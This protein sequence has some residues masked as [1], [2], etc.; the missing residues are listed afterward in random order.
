MRSLRG[1]IAL[2]FIVLILAVFAAVGLLAQH[3]VERSVTDM[4]TKHVHEVLDLAMLTVENGYEEYR[5][6]GEALLRERR[7]ALEDTLQLAMAAVESSYRRA[8]SGVITREAA[9]HSAMETL[10]GMRYADGAGYF[11]VQNDRLPIPMMLMHAAMPELEWKPCTHPLMYKALGDGSNLTA[12]FVEA[13]RESE[14]G[15]AFV[16]YRWPKPTPEGLTEIEPKLSCVQL[17]EPWGWVVGTGLYVDD[18]EDEC[19]THL[20]HISET[21]F[22]SLSEIELGR[23][24]YLFVFTDDGEILMHPEIADGNGAVF[25]DSRKKQEILS[26]LIEAAE[27][28][29]GRHEYLGPKPQGGNGVTRKISFVRFFEPLGW[30]IGAAVYRSELVAPAV[31][32]G[33]KILWITAG[34][35]VVAVLLALWLARGISRPLAELADSARR[36]E[37]EGI[38]A[39]SLPVRGTSETRALG[40]CLQNMISSLC[41]REEEL[42]RLSFLVASAVSPLVMADLEGRLTYVNPAF[43]ATWGYRSEEEVLG[44]EIGEFWEIDG[45]LEELRDTIWT[46]EAVQREERARKADG[47]FFD[48]QFSAALVRDNSG[49]PIALMASSVDITARRRA[50]AEIERSNEE[51]RLINRKLENYS[52][53]I[54]HDLKEPIRSIRTFSEFIREDYAE[55]FDEEAADYFARIIRAS[56]RMARMIDDLLLLSRVGRYDVAFRRVSVTDLVR[57]AE[58]NLAPKLEDQGATLRYPELP[59][60]VCQ[61]VWLE[62][63][64]RNLVGNALKYGDKEHTVVEVGYRELPEH[65]LF[66]LRDNGRGIEKDQWERVFELFRKGHQNRGIEGSGAGLAIVA[67]VAEQHQG[68]AWV[69][70]SVPGEGTTMAFTISKDLHQ[71]EET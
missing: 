25:A 61:P 28:P 59:E 62:M 60:V 69:E 18:I 48:V 44:R 6:H 27:E 47:T 17:F 4:E 71:S 1:R 32:L 30:Y 35:L 15:K 38:E 13:C 66:T 8:R 64:F 49:R 52:Y 39:A 22:T 24:G 42:H 63:V 12:H 23:S 37:S 34:F 3:D 53:T 26:A 36:I 57:E 58:A 56:D 65:H 31:A 46:E 20:D 68:S 7:S 19:V 54:S 67:S 43:L 45:Y 14:D 16:T 33:T 70:A 10:R 55:H 29:G 2:A 50:E 11:W 40:L 51:L 9:R 5:Y 21:M 41:T